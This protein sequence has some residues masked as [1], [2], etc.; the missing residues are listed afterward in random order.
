MRALADQAFSRAAGAPLI[1]GN[2]V[3]VLRDATENY[4]A[5]EQAIA[6]ARH[7]IHIEMYIIHRDAVGRRLVHDPR[8]R[9]CTLASVTS[10]TFLDSRVTS[11]GYREPAAGL[12]R[13]HQTK[14]F[15][16]GA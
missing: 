16:A 11:V 10:F 1:A 2:H 7:T 13:P 6:A 12:L 4:P 9:E 3:Q 15:V 14:K 8:K 5:W